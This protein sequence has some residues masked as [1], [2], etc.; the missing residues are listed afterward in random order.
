MDRIGL[1]I[2]LGDLE[3][4]GTEWCTAAKINRYQKHLR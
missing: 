3:E 4:W 1:V 2:L